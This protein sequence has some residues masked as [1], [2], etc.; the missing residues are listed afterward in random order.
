MSDP[1]AAVPTIRGSRRSGLYTLPVAAMVALPPL[2]IDMVL[3]A[4]P[5][6][7]SSLHA[8]IGRAG[9]AISLFLV[10]FAIS[11]VVLGPL[12]D[13]L[14]RRPVMLASCALFS[15]AGLGATFSGSLAGLL[16]LRLFQGIGAGGCMVVVFAVVRDL[17]EGDEVRSRLATAN[18]IMGIA[19]M[20]APTAGALFLTFTGWRGLFAFL[21]LG[22]ATLLVA[23]GA[24]LGESIGPRRR[25]VGA[26]ELAAGY[27][28]VLSVRPVLGCALIAGLSFGL[29][30]AYVV[31]SSFLFLGILHV[32]PRVYGLIFA[33]IASGQIVGATAAASLARR[34]VSHVT[35]LLGGILLGL[36]GSGVLLFLAALGRVRVATAIPSLLFVT[37]ALGLI[38]PSAAH[39]V[40]APMP[41][42]AGTASAVLGF[43]RMSGGALASALVSLSSAKSPAALAVLMTLFASGALVAWIVAVSPRGRARPV[44]LPLP[45]PSG[46][47]AP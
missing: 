27:L 34:G 14:G 10:G 2:S 23:C 3:P 33:A 30:Q 15:A 39:G 42:V 37:T 26:G 8:P 12:S 21:G 1:A 35:V 6:I 44:P 11:Q 28:Q 41:H 36:S 46:P 22:G 5:S 4:L 43:V 31:G 24:G 38:A 45:L 17:F 19:P 47:Q 32:T 20:V 29:L 16:S 7:A 9:L 25:R 18:A 13:R 40:L